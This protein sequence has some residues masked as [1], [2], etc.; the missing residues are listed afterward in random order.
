MLSFFYKQLRKTKAGFSLIEVV[1]YVGLFSSLSVMSMSSL[2]QTIK[3]FNNLRI[4][5]DIDDSAVKIMERLTRDVKSSTAIDI[6]NSTFGTSP[7]RLTLTTVS[8]SGTPLKVEYF[9]TNSSLHI[10][11]NDIDIGAL[12]STKTSIDALVFYYINT[13]NTVGIK[14]ELHISSTRNA[15]RDADNFYN[16]SLVRGTY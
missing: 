8:A 4:S 13:G 11:E 10:K 1:F 3:A 6:A 9:V 12:M 16:T 5:R 7:G 2:F 14:S 15:V